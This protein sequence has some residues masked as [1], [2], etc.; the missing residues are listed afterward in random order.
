MGPRSNNN[1]ELKQ[2]VGDAENIIHIKDYYS[3]RKVKSDVLEKI[4]VGKL[5]PPFH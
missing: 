5:D 1:D 3:L 2:I 4:D